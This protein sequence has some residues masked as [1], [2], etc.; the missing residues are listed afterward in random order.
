ML[1]LHICKTSALH[2]TNKQFE[3]VFN[4]D[5]SFTYGPSLQIEI[6]V[7]CPLVKRQRMLYQAV[8]N[9]ISIEDLLQ[10][11]SSNTSVAQTSTS[12]LMNLVMQFRKV[13]WLKLFS[14]HHYSLIL[15]WCNMTE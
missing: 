6:L 1:I 12:S 10:S 8:K 7:Y 15:T 11:S 13:G 14:L 4:R 5:P 2:L 9:K 3:I